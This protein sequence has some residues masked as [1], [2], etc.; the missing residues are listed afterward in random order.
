MR[1]KLEKEG[2]LQKDCNNRTGR[3]VPAQIRLN[4][5][6]TFSLNSAS[7]IITGDDNQRFKILDLNNRESTLDDSSQGLQLK[8]PKVGNDYKFSLVTTSDQPY[9]YYYDGKNTIID[10]IDHIPKNYTNGNYFHTYNPNRCSAAYEP[11]EN[12]KVLIDPK[13]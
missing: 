13:T 7:Y 11:L 6:T 8:L 12:S 10:T 3:R 1:F 4:N 2:I 5:K 9:Y